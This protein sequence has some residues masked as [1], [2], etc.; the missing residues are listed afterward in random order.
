MKLE[1]HLNLITLTSQANTIKCIYGL[2]WYRAYYWTDESQ[3]PGQVIGMLMCS[4]TIGTRVDLLLYIVN[5]IWTLM[6]ALSFEKNFKDLHGQC[7]L[8]FPDF[9]KQPDSIETYRTMMITILHLQSMYYNSEPMQLQVLHVLADVMH[10]HLATKQT[11]H[12]A[13]SPDGSESRSLCH[14]Q[15]SKDT[16]ESRWRGLFHCSSTHTLV[17]GKRIMN[18]II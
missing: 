12:G 15:W 1:R 4:L 8:W 10:A 17:V 11:H 14:V 3:D 2:V 9:L 18:V 7:V 13:R 5:C 6:W 16:L